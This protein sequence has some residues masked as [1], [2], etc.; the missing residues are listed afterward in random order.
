MS[1]S[2]MREIFGRLLRDPA[3][4]PER[5]AAVVT[6]VSRRKEAARIYKWHKATGRFPPRRPQPD[7]S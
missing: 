1:V 7:T 6:R 2:Q 4:S 3:P 5:I